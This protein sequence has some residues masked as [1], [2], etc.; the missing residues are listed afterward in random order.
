MWTY[1]TTVAGGTGATSFS[2]TFSESGSTTSSE[3]ASDSFGGA[4]ATEFQTLVSALAGTI[5]RNAY[6]SFS[7]F[8][9]SNS[10]SVSNNFSPGSPFTSSSAGSS[11]SE[12]THG[13][14]YSSTRYTTT[15]SAA[16]TSS[17]SSSSEST[18]RTLQ[19][20]ENT[21]SSYTT[22]AGEETT[23]TASTTETVVTTAAGPTTTD[24]TQTATHVTTTTTPA[25]V[26]RTRLST[27][28][29]TTISAPVESLGIT[30]MADSEQGWSVTETYTAAGYASD[31]A[32]TFT[33]RTETPS[34]SS[35]VLPGS[36]VNTFTLVQTS[37]GFPTATLVT[38]TFVSTVD[39]YVP[40]STSLPAT[41]T[42]TRAFS[43][44]STTTTTVQ[45]WSQVTFVATFTGPVSG[46]V[47]T[48]API[49]YAASATAPFTL[50]ASPTS[51]FSDSAH[52]TWASTST[53]SRY[54]YGSQHLTSSLS[55]SAASGTYTTSTTATGTITSTTST[56][57][58]TTTDVETTTDTTT[59]VTS[60]ITVV[61]NT[62]TS[63]TS[64]M[65]EPD[66]TTV[67]FTSV[68]GINTEFS[69]DFPSFTQ[70][71][72]DGFTTFTVFEYWTYETGRTSTYTYSTDG[73]TEVA[74]GL[75]TTRSTLITY[76]VWSVTSSESYSSFWY[77]G[78]N[79]S[80]FFT[81]S[82]AGGFTDSSSDQFTASETFN[83]DTITF[84]TS[85]NTTT[86][87]TL[88]QATTATTTAT[89]FTEGT[90]VDTESTSTTST[91]DTTT[92]MNGSAAAGTTNATQNGM[93]IGYRLRV[94]QGTF[95]F[96]AN[97]SAHAMHPV[98]GWRSPTQLETSDALFSA[99]SITP[100][101]IPY[102]FLA[103]QD[104]SRGPVT[105]KLYANGTSFANGASTYSVQF[106]TSNN[107]LYYTSG[108]S[109]DTTSAT[110][111]ASF[112]GVGS[113]TWY[114]DKM[115][116]RGNGT[117]AFD[118]SAIGGI[119]N[120]SAFD[121]R[122]YILPGVLHRT[123]QSEGSV[124]AS[125]TTVLNAPSTTEFSREGWAFPTRNESAWGV[126]VTT[127]TASYN[128]VL[129][130]VVF[131]GT[132]ANPDIVTLSKY[133]NL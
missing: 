65:Y 48:A 109:S 121:A 86:T 105:P 14:T 2:S 87:I 97:W 43:L 110:G 35:S 73:V 92:V 76:E 46:V 80:N 89:T 20:Y 82:N 124:S 98:N 78:I 56:T 18:V 117:G 11:R 96:S 42:T 62:T 90:T 15:D 17:S 74:G 33:K 8:Q 54:I 60:T 125:D 127:T 113:V 81:S 133:P 103:T 111:T 108:I 114:S 51:T 99:L 57:Y 128:S 119:P 71:T 118:A 67:D 104:D 70:E 100:V 37:I 47:T 68:T 1:N 4:A 32:A 6:E 13:F 93:T 9:F 122:V 66:G 36:P 85:T 79:F 129:G 34:S 107:R 5:V 31:F 44:L 106:R 22:T 126:S 25:T 40:S 130:V 116:S 59:N 49:N 30:E 63:T 55:T 91:G 41:D 131:D 83:A 64:S 24:T 38:T 7:T 26:T 12:V 94:P 53:Y 72:V 112:S 95:T 102:P 19:S 88:T 77:D 52:L 10:A 101:S 61:D 84:T 27:V 28:A 69:Q 123:T 39:T 23:T 3:S 132:K 29:S 58:S 16:S 21:I 75:K 115:T 45:S 50:N 120:R